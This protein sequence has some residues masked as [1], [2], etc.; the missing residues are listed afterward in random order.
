MQQPLISVTV[1][2]TAHTTTKETPHIATLLIHNP[3]P[4]AREIRNSRKRSLGPQS[5][6]SLPEC[7]ICK[8]RKKTTLPNLLPLNLQISTSRSTQCEGDAGAKP[9]PKPPLNSHL[10]IDLKYAWWRS[11]M[12]I[13]S[14]S[15]SFYRLLHEQVSFDRG[16]RWTRKLHLHLTTSFFSSSLF[17]G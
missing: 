17:Q 14:D 16:S 9:K 3:S 8:R 4:N 10:I 11:K 5:T 2:K 6:F 7:A 13:N 1:D 12:S 15:D